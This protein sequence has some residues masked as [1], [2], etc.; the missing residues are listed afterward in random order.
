MLFRSVLHALQ[1]NTLPFINDGEPVDVPEI[2][3]LLSLAV[4][5]VTLAVTAVA[6]L[7]ASRKMSDEEVEERTSNLK[8][9]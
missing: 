4:I 8:A 2:S 7:L 9:E 3:S 6:S 5:I 1:K